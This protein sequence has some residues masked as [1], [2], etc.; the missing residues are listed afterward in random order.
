[1]GYHNGM[2]NKGTF[3]KTESDSSRFWKKVEKSE[4][5]WTWMGNKGRGGYGQFRVGSKMVR[6]H[7]FSWMEVHGSISEDL[8]VCHTC[9]NPSCVRPDHLFLGTA[10]DNS[11]D[12]VAK[13]RQAQGDNT[14]YRKYPEKRM[15]GDKNPSRSHP[16]SHPRGERHGMAKITE[17]DVLKIREMYATGEHTQRNLAKQFGVTQT[18]VHF[19]VKRLKWAHI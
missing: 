17:S 3:K 6:S 14:I 8:F 2:A 7:R 1:M 16:E 9:D 10:A 19:I 13:G 5:C 11:N 18:L 4:R 15:I 12:K